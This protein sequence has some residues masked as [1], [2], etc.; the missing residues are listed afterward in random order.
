MGDICLVLSHIGNFETAISSSYFQIL[1]LRTDLIPLNF[2]IIDEFIPKFEKWIISIRKESFEQENFNEILDYILKFEP[3]FVDIDEDCLNEELINKVISKSELIISYHNYDHTPDFD[4]LQNKIDKFVEL[5]AKMVKIVCKGAKNSDFATVSKLYNKNNNLICFLMGENYRQSRIEAYFKG[6]KIT[7]ARL[8]NAKEVAA[9]IP[10]LENLKRDLQVFEKNLEKSIEVEPFKVSGQ[11]SA[12]ASKSHVQRLLA[13]AI[14]TKGKTIINGFEGSKD[15]D[16]FLKIVKELGFEVQLTNN[17]LIIENSNFNFLN[18]VSVNVG[19]SGLALRM[20]PFILSNIAHEYEIKAT[21]TLL[22][23]PLNVFL[24]SV[25]ASGIEILSR[26]FPLKFRGRIL[27]SEIFI[28]GSF[29]S[30]M[31]SGLLISL[32]LQS[33]DTVVFVKDLNSKP[34]IDMTLEV[35][36]KFGIKVEVENYSKFTIKGNQNYQNHEIKADGD[37]SGIANFLV[38]AA[39]SGKV[40]VENLDINSP[41]ADKAILEVLRNFGAKI[42][43]TNSSVIIENCE[44]RPFNFDCTHAP[45]LFPILTVLAAKAKGI[46][47]I[48][49]WKRLLHKESNRCAAIMEIMG[50]FGVEIQLEEDEMLVFGNGKIEGGLTINPHSDHRLAMMASIAATLADD[51]ITILNPDVVE[52]SYPDF[53]RTLERVKILK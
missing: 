34:Y 50:K 37:W 16:A 43:I 24:E 17:Q 35:M 18:S 2:E 47:R 12:N 30:Q 27:K 32:P 21:S 39:I 49:G 26:K 53:F 23:R 11:I 42:D 45:D 29:S 22:N 13:I 7:Y 41:Q 8:E 15:V 3:K 20:M 48:K 4:F 52:K 1:E 5:G 33:K 25:E 44:F 46:S 40:E 9:G 19:E 6:A 36:S 14:L 10:E 28:D 31:L 38:A 51:K